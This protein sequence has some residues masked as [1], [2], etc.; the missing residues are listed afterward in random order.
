MSGTDNNSHNQQHSEADFH[1]DSNLAFLSQDQLE[2]ITQK[3]TAHVKSLTAQAQQMPSPQP[4]PMQTIKVTHI[5]PNIEPPQYN[6]SS[7]TSDSYFAKC[8]SFFTSQGLASHLYHTAC[9][10]LMKGNMQLWYDSV[11]ESIDS[12]DKFKSVFK[13]RFDNESSQDRR[14]YLLMTRTQQYNE[15]C[16]QFILEMVNLGRQVNPN[17]SENKLVKHAFDKLVPT[18]RLATGNLNNLTVNALLENLAATYNTIRDNDQAQGTITR[19]P[20]LYGYTPTI[21]YDNHT[22]DFRRGTNSFPRTEFQSQ[23]FEYLSGHQQPRHNFNNLPPVLHATSTQLQ[24]PTFNLNAP[25][26][27]NSQ[28]SQPRTLLSSEL[29]TPTLHTPNDFRVPH[30]ELFTV[31]CH[32]CQQPGHFERDCPHFNNTTGTNG[33]RYID[34]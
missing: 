24:Q 25:N 9:H 1:K 4:P 2:Y 29:P 12:W 8:E 32:K 10:V 14:R 21:Q 27:Q 17:E 30:H 18:I 7:M 33:F 23:P 11:A 31:R 6:A 28:Q 16:E 20:P 19:L 3:V 34:D 5:N 15:S 13:E 26:F 22:N